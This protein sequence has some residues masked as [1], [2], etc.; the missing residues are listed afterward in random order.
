MTAIASN[1]GSEVEWSSM[2][3]LRSTT[4]GVSCARRWAC[5]A[6]PKP[7]APSGTIQCLLRISGPHLGGLVP[8]RGGS[9]VGAKRTLDKMYIWHNPLSLGSLLSF[10][11]AP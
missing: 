4:R 10:V 2:Y 9:Y 5:E 3:T 8:S 6:S 1:R 7:T 11:H